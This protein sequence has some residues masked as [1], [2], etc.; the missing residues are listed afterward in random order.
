MI[1][2]SRVTTDSPRAVREMLKTLARLAG[3]REDYAIRSATALERWSDT[4][5]PG[6][7]AS[8]RDRLEA[9]ARTDRSKADTARHLLIEAWVAA[10]YDE[11]GRQWIPRT[12][13]ERFADAMIKI[14]L[15]E[16]D[17]PDVARL[18]LD[19]VFTGAIEVE[20]S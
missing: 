5:Q 13:A 1:F 10:G 3:E 17:I 7:A 2:R 11:D 16:R 14:V 8:T 9:G 6:Q 19:D 4:A 20:V 15:A 18:E 12:A